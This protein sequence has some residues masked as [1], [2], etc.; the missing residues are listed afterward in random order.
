MKKWTAL[1][2]VRDESNSQ[3]PE[4]NLWAKVL[5]LGIREAL[6]GH[7]QSR[8]WILSNSIK[9]QSFFWVCSV[10]D[11]EPKAV[12]ELIIKNDK[13]FLKRI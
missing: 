13:D 3:I 6:K 8:M 1:L 7:R 12:R 9:P 5:E 2:V 11:L 4:R 10:L